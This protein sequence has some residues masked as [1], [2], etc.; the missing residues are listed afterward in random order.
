V[1]TV[2]DYLEEGLLRKLGLSGWL[3]EPHMKQARKNI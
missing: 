2:E 1:K 3:V